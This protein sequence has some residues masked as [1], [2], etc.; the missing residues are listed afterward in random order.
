MDPV[1]SGYLTREV[2]VEI[3]SSSRLN[4]FHWHWASVAVGYCVRGRLLWLLL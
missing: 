3:K 4:T 1:V 2:I